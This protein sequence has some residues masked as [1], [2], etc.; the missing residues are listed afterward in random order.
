VERL[1]A[2]K[3]TITLPGEK[4]FLRTLRLRLGRNACV[5]GLEAFM[6]DIM[7]SRNALVPRRGLYGVWIRTQEGDDARLIR[8]WIDPSMTLFESQVEVRELDVLPART[9]I[10]EAFP[11]ASTS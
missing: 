3:A 5:D 2:S 10:Q 6:F 4:Y 9:V 7:T 8:V 1:G 11:K